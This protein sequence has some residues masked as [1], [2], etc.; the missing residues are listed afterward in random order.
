MDEIH[1]TMNHTKW[2]DLSMFKNLTIW[3]KMNFMNYNWN[4]NGVDNIDDVKY[5]KY[6][7]SQQG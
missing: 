1:D 7:I 6:K 5:H 4:I 2:M 3:M